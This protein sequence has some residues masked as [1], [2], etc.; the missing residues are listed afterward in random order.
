LLC[1]TG[2]N[3]GWICVALLFGLGCSESVPA[4]EPVPEE[5]WVRA[6]SEARCERLFACCTAEER[7]A[8]LST[9]GSPPATAEECVEEAV[10]TIEDLFGDRERDPRVR[11]DA[12]AAGRCS[13]AIASLTCD[14]L[15]GV[16]GD[17]GFEL[18]ACDAIFVPTV[19]DGAACAAS[20]QCLSGYCA[21]DRVD[22]EGVCGDPPR[23]GEPCELGTCADGLFCDLE[24]RLCR[25][26]RADGEP[27]R[28]DDDCVHDC[29]G[30]EDLFSIESRG[31]CGVRTTC[32]P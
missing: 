27:C 19:E 1:A 11:Y 13:A 7:A 29:V 17:R 23:A 25:T 4:A 28:F 15:Y 32:A 30:R 26:Q 10:S 8:W 6:F 5:D 2:M 31:T 21:R 14:E 16:Y 18:E 12:D 20:G 9:T 24:S 3:S 22:E